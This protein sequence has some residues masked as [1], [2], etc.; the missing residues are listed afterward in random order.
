MRDR[1]DFTLTIGTGEYSIT[2]S[3][4]TGLNLPNF[5]DAIA[6]TWTTPSGVTFEPADIGTMT[7]EEAEIIYSSG[8][9]GNPEL[10]IIEDETLRIYPEDPDKL[11]DCRFY[12]WNY[13][14]NPQLNT[15]SDVLTKRF[16]MTL[17]YASIAYGYEMILKDF[18]A[19]GYFRQLLG[20]QPFGR[21]GELAKIKKENFKRGWQDDVALQPRTGPGVRYRRRIDNL[22]IYR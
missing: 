6:F 12:H 13:T 7:R 15:A 14:T 10:I 20:G 5:K 22:Q 17:A 21:G 3:S 1:K 19:A 11:Y 18:N 4:G 2:S 9:D 8:D 16:P